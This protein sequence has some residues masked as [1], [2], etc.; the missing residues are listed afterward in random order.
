VSVH[1]LSDDETLVLLALRDGARRPAE[2]RRPPARARN[3][4][5]QALVTRGLVLQSGRGRNIE[6]ALAAEAA[7]IVATL[8][9]PATAPKRARSQNAD[10]TAAIMRLEAALARIEAKVDRLLAEP[11]DAPRPAVPLAQLKQTIL[12]AVKT[13][14]ARHRFGGLVPLP[15]LRR[16]LSPLGVERQ[17]VDAALTELEREY[18]VDLNIAQAPSTVSERQAGIERPGRGLIYYVTRRSS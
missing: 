4:A 17:S 13:L 15:D 12:D 14:D 3:N 7:P 2:I 1:D 9:A 5:L 10:M 8:V 11:T 6:L 18:A 16:A